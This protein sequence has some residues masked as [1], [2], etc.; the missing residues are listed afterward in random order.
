MANQYKQKWMELV[1]KRKVKAAA[2]IG[3]I[4]R[5]ERENRD[6]TPTEKTSFDAL[7][8]EVETI[9]ERIERLQAAERI[10]TSPGRQ[11]IP[12]PVGSATSDPRGGGGFGNSGRTNGTSDDGLIRYRDVRSGQTVFG[13][14]GNASYAAHLSQGSVAG[15]AFAEPGSIGRWCQ[16][17]ASP[18]RD[19]RFLLPDERKA[20]SYFD[21]SETVNH[22]GGYLTPEVLI[23]SEFIDRLRKRMVVLQAGGVTLPLE[24]DS[25]TIGRLAGGPTFIGAHMENVAE[26]TTNLTFDSVGLYPNTVMCLLR[27]SDEWLMDCPNGAALIEDTLVREL[28]QKLDE[29]ALAGTGSAQPTGLLYMTGLNTQTIGTLDWADL[30]D[31]IT[32]CRKDNVEPTS[33]ICNATNLNTLNKLLVNSEAN[34]YAVPPSD[35]A[36]LRKFSTEAMPANTLV[37]GDFSQFIF[38]VRQDVTIKRESQVDRN[39]QL[40]SVTARVAFA[41]QH[42]EAFCKIS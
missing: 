39:S 24:S 19:T 5:A 42:P 27:V 32:E 25:N 17:V 8:D 13:F 14:T 41:V 11:S 38:A 30:L 21:Q 33:W 16:F 29:Y 26:S 28:S 10:T 34:H 23:S 36:A 37:V 40:I 6:M 18:N 12:P 9:E 7:Q 3:F 4:E 22:L 2:A 15:A 20:L 31:A 35:V 1:A